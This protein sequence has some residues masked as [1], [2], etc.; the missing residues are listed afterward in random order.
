LEKEKIIGLTRTEKDSSHY[1][2]FILEREQH[3]P[4]VNMNRKSFGR[5]E[6]EIALVRTEI[7]ST[8]VTTVNFRLETGEGGDAPNPI[9]ISK[10]TKASNSTV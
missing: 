3:R 1:Y 7:E 5:A 6:T 9:S 10:S 4:N 8:L 2:E